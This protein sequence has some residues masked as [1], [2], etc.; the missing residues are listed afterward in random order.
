VIVT[1]LRLCVFADAPNAAGLRALDIPLASILREEFCQ[2]IFGANYLELDV[3]PVRG[4]GLDGCAAG[5]APPRARL[6]FMRGG[7]G[8]LLRVFFALMGRIKARAAD[9]AAGAA[10]FAPAALALWVTAQ[11][12]Y[13]D[14][15]DP[16]RLYVVQPPGG[17]GGGACGGAGGGAAP[18]GY[19]PAQR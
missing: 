14:P 12:A 17:G 10:F 4:A 5:G 1:T 6:Y 15:S 7:A 13:V 18:S 9:A 8:T 3:A 16:S 19:S 2:P 11:E